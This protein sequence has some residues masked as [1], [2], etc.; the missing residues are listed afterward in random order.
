[1]PLS[2]DRPVAAR[3]AGAQSSGPAQATETAESDVEPPAA[4][5]QTASAEERATL[6][7]LAPV[8]P[9]R[10]S[11][12]ALRRSLYFTT[13]AWLFGA[14]WMSATGG[15][16]QT[17]LAMHLGVD[18][19]LFGVIASVGFIGVFLQI[20]GSLLTEWLGRRRGIF[21]WWV[22]AHRISYF[23]IAAIPWLL[24]AHTRGTAWVMIMLLL[25]SACAANF[26]APAW[27][28]WMS[29]L[30][31][32]R[33][34]G[35]YFARRA[36][37]A[38]V[39]MALTGIG[40]GLL[41]DLSGTDAFQHLMLPLSDKAGMPPLIVVI[42]AIFF[43]AGVAGIVDIQS[44][45]KVDEP[46]MRPAS[47]EAVLV[48]LSRPVR[49]TNFMRYCAYYGVWIFALA[50]A[51]GFWWVYLLDFFETQR[52]A[53]LTAWWL[54]HKY[55]SAYLF[56]QVG[57]NIGQFV[58]YPLWGA[59]VDRFGRKPVIFLSSMLHSLAWLPWLFLGP[60]MVVWLFP[61]Q[62]YGGLMGS[63][64]ELA[65]FNVMLGFNRKGG[66]GY[67]AIGSVIFAIAGA[68]ACIAA[69]KFCEVLHQTDTTWT[70]LTGTPW[71][72]TFNRYAMVVMVALCL[73]VLADLVM[74]K[75]VRDVEAKS[76]RHA[77]RFLLTNMYG[78]LN[79]QIFTPMRN[80]PQQAINT[81]GQVGD[82]VR[83]LGEKMMSGDED[84]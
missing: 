43:I 71:Q 67:Q 12:D 78:N 16:T 24:P 65:N 21:L 14:F 28:H 62:I 25:F 23:L 1:M 17:R 26:G 69:G 41:M 59:V 29:D 63:G 81:L 50:F 7:Q 5:S 11:G 80:M 18:D 76:T 74:L 10:I 46:R 15:A 37:L 56:L 57:Y 75:L 68:V 33:V 60:N 38:I 34:R 49:D 84:E 54:E 70:I 48:R 82:H 72:W 30:V 83:R 13:F 20:P 45:H 55:V 35:K 40:L 9:E 3:G 22:T 77:M 58:G 8:S 47:R 66:P 51:Q 6:A 73:K 39:V 42:S 61:T 31:P 4:V 19:F 36:R 64:Q 32:A 53:G 52:K 79:T 2:K 27:T 44:F